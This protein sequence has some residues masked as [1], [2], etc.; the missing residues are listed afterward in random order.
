MLPTR[1]GVPLMD[2]VY[3][4]LTFGFAALTWGFVRLCEKV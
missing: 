2:A 4:A 3:L 1:S